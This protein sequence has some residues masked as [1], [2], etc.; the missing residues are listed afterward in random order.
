[1]HLKFITFKLV[2][3]LDLPKCILEILKS[4]ISYI[5][6]FQKINMPKNQEPNK[7]EKS[8]KNQESKKKG[9]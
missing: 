7:N 2:S 6:Y 3:N 5:Q 1:M 4:Y 8:I 9:K